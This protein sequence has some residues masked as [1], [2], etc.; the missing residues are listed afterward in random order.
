MA[1][2]HRIT[3]RDFESFLSSKYDVL[4]SK[5]PDRKKNGR[6]EEQTDSL[7]LKTPTEK[8]NN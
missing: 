4:V 8:E 3:K 6:V 2:S 5:C 7:V 1:I